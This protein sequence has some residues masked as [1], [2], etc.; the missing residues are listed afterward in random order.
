MVNEFMERLLRCDY[1][2][3]IQNLVP[4]TGIK[5]MKNSVLDSSN[6]EVYRKPFHLLLKRTKLL[7]V[8]RINI[9]QIIPAASC[10]LRH[11]IG[12]APCFHTGLRVHH[13]YPIRHIG[14][15]RFTRTGRFDVI[16]IRKKQRKLILRNSFYG[17]V[18]QMKNRNRLSPV[19]LAAEQ[20]VSKP[21][22]YFLPSFA[23]FLEPFNHAG[24]A[25]FF[26]Q[27]I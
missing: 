1:T 10:P 8:M 9:P 19:T 17:A 15:W 24:N 6:V 16:H 25:L 4:E 2:K 18:F 5:Q 22:G 20:P 3:I 26:I 27:T 7:V 13:I 11:C 23:L 12:L 14:Q 21:V